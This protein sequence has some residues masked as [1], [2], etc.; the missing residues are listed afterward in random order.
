MALMYLMDPETGA[1]RRQRLS[2]S[3]SR[4]AAEMREAAE[5]AWENASE[6][7]GDKFS[8]TREEAAS[9]LSDTVDSARA[10]AAE[11]A[12]GL[13]AAGKNLV[14]SIRERVGEKTDD[15]R[16]GARIA[17]TGEREH[18]YVGQ[19]V[20]AL[21]SLALGAGALWAL[22]PRLGRSRRAWL[23][24]KST[25][26]LREVGDFFRATGRRISGPMQGTVA[27]TRSYFRGNQP[28]NDETL[29]ARVRSSLGRVTDNL[30]GI[31]VVVR[32]GHVTLGGNCPADEIPS[33][34][35]AVLD[36]RGVRGVDVQASQAAP[37][38][39]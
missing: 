8:E 33:L 7:I 14:H 25:H 29:C 16:R 24:D 31:E 4:R 22:D 9:R 38:G 27:E 6:R 30:S 15:V 28:V 35:D 32:G 2:R 18:H 10:T 20:C 26:W 23:R 19:S 37:T 21:G 17:L 39:I 12:G 34:R 11:T 5:S 13:L 1:Q 3:A 36:V